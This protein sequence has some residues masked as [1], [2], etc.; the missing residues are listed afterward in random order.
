MKLLSIRSMVAAEPQVRPVR[1]L[2]CTELAGVLGAEAGPSVS[3]T[4]PRARLPLR[5]WSL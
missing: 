2:P 1:V 5:K 3:Q 4:S